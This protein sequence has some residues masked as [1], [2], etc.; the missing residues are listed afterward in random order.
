M[1]MKITDI[2]PEIR[3]IQQNGKT[4]TLDKSQNS[5]AGKNPFSAESKEMKK[6]HD[7]LAVTPDVRA[8][9][10]DALKK[11]IESGQYDV[12]SDALASKMI[13]DFLTET[14]Q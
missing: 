14:N 1:S 6:I 5:P 3:C 10:V 7:V 12:K 11:L 13:K 9:R 4:T 8:E 2:P